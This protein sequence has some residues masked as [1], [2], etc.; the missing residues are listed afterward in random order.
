MN[1]HLTEKGN[2]IL[3]IFM[4]IS[5]YTAYYTESL[6]ITMKLVYKCVVSTYLLQKMNPL[7]Y[8]VKNYFQL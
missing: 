5:R 1:F 6:Y 4:N 8:N 3:I 2:A 7:V